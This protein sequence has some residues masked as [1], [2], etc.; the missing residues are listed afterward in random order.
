MGYCWILA[1]AS[2]QRST[3]VSVFEL[4]VLSI[5]LAVMDVLARKAA[6]S[7]HLM[8]PIPANRQPLISTT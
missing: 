3:A 5:A 7:I 8:R 6:P 2:S 1:L 4:A